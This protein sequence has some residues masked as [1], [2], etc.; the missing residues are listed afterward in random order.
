MEAT[1]MWT[2]L[3]VLQKVFSAPVWEFRAMSWCCR[4][5]RVNVNS[6]DPF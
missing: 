1:E 6:S 3:E 5:L 4:K 2:Y